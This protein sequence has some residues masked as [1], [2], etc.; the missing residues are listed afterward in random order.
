MEKIKYGL[1]NVHYAVLTNEETLEYGEVKPIKGAVNLS[2]SAEGE[3]TPFY[4][5]NVVYFM[6]TT[7]NGF[8]GDLEMALIPDEFLTDVLGYE[9][10]KST[11]LLVE[12]AN[13]ISKPIALMFQFEND[14][15]SRRV[16]MY[17]VNIGRAGMDHA[18]KNETIEPKTDTLPITVIPVTMEDKTI[19]KA[20]ANKQDKS[21]N[22]FFSEVQKPTFT[23]E[24]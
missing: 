3:S 13:A 6:T 5:D 14:T 7:N 4:A 10:D 15:N 17:K 16:V 12:I 19:T 22:T 1:S 9:K 8:T 21:Y 23:S 20:T 24:E 2:L 11:G 18:T